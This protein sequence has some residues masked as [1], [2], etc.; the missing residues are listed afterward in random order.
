MPFCWFCHDAAQIYP[1][2][3]YHN[4]VVNDCRSDLSSVNNSEI[5][6]LAMKERDGM[7]YV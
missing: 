3:S 2:S 6:I 7:Q 1:S 4:I 5:L